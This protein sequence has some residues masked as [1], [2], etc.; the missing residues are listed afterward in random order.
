MSDE[1][2]TFPYRLRPD[3]LSPSETAFYHVLH[4][5]TRADFFICPKVALSDL[6]FVTRPNENVQYSNKLLR[7]NVDF[8]LLR[9][10][11]LLPALEEA[12]DHDVPVVVVSQCIRGYVDLGRYEGGVMAA[13]TGAISAG[14][15][16][17]ESAIAKLMI[18]IARHGTG[19]ALRTWF[20]SSH[21]G[22]R[23]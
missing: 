1:P 21:V 9:S 12:R 23:D 20:A 8:L 4:Y 16:T 7:K 22:E 14:D 18:G 15:M 5:L 3:F 17:V 11:T 19:D 10:E 6:L 2:I 13:D